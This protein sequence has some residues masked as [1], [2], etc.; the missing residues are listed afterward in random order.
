[1]SLLDTIKVARA[2][3]EEAQDARTKKSDATTEGNE[4][5]APTST[6]FSRRSVARAKPKR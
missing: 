5:A 3:A 1:M 2:E 4:S 6:G